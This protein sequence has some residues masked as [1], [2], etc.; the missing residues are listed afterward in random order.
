MVSTKYK[1]HFFFFAIY[2][3]YK[4]KINILISYL[5]L[6]IFFK[7]V[8]LTRQFHNRVDKVSV[9]GRLTIVKSIMV[10][11]WISRMC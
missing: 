5:F 6:I 9:E 11:L 2:I 10:L 8:F 3:N 4:I 7:H 1:F